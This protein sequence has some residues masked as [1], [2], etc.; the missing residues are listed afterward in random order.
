MLLT[1]SALSLPAAVP[2]AAHARTTYR[3]SRPV[4]SAAPYMGKA[5]SVSGVVTPASTAKARAVVKLRL[6]VE[7]GGKYDVM[8]LYTAKDLS[9]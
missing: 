4:L 9:R 6:M 1:A 5:F 7:T 8:D 2:A 3:T